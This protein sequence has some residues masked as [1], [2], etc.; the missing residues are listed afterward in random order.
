M[1]GCGRDRG[2][3]TRVALKASVLRDWLC[4]EVGP[5]QPPATGPQCPRM[6]ALLSQHEKRGGGSDSGPKKPLAWQALPRG[7]VHPP[8]ADWKQGIR[9]V[10]ICL[11]WAR[12]LQRGPG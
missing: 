4:Q 5:G 1:G 10:K 9:Q 12:C 2:P 11:P 6:S 7:A 3:G 8:S